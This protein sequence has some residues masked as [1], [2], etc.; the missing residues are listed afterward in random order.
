MV[1]PTEL[2]L[3]RIAY[4]LFLISLELSLEYWLWFASSPFALAID[5]GRN[6]FFFKCGEKCPIGHVMLSWHH[7]ERTVDISI[8]GI[9]ES[10]QS[11]HPVSQF[12]MQ[13]LK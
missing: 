11:S 5:N 12:K 6:R 8:Y 9:R 7:H 4:F 3:D 1:L 10:R 2:C 13:V